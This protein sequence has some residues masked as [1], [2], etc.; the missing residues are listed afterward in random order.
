MYA[1]PNLIFPF[2][3]GYVIDRVGRRMCLIFFVFFVT[4]GQ[5]LFAVSA[6]KSINSYWLAVAARFL[7]GY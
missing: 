2:L 6:M 3:M 1:F 7:F 4:M 5:A